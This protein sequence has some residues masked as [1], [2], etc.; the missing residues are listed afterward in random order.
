MSNSTTEQIVSRSQLRRE[1]QAVFALARDLVAL[2][3]GKLAAI[4]LPESI[5]DALEKARRIKQHVARKRET[6]HVAK[7]LREIDCEPIH[8]ALYDSAAEQRQEAARQHRCEDWR[9]A[10][11]DS[12]RNAMTQLCSARPGIDVGHLRQLV[13]TALKEL[14]QEKPPTASRQLFRSLREIDIQEA[15]PPLS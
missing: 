12:S 15:L 13:R 5:R 1:A 10:L 9:D 3:P 6:Q 7:L 4:P 2:A 14:K 8:S 11:L